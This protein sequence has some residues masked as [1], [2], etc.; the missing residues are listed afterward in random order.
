MLELIG[1]SGGD[2]VF[3]RELAGLV[4]AAG[5]T[6][7][8]AEGYFVPF[9]TDAVVGLA[10]SNID[11]LGAAIVE[12]GLMSAAELDR[13]RFILER[14]DCLYPASMALISAWGRR[15]VA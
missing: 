6:E 4:K 3:A 13:Y 7:V 10:M 9:R 15:Q 5:L 14:P 1:H 11:Q 12:A 8:G 2:P